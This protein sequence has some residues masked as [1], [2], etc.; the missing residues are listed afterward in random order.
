MKTST[1]AGWLLAASLL[2]GTAQAADEITVTAP[3]IR[4]TVAQATA[5]GVFM[6][7][8]AQHDARLLAVRT[9]IGRAE[10]HQMA[11]E[12]QTMSMRAVDGVDL[13]AGQPVNLSSGGLHVM[14]MDL[15]HQ[16]REG[17]VVPL[18]LVIQ[19]K[20][21]KPQNV[22]VKATVKALS[23]LPPKS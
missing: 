21:K 1:W 13:P 22:E 14:L 16:V 7:I 19:E 8:T 20:G 11:M 12:G 17:D 5:T 6:Q 2:G 10:L 4:A 9:A 15:K 23:Y 18:T 3:W